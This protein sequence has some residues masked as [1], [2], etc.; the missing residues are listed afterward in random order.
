MVYFVYNGSCVL[1]HVTESINSALHWLRMLH[2]SGDYTAHIEHFE[3]GE[4]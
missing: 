3:R 2:W 1:V 4:F